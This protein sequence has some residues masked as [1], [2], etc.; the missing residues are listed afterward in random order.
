MIDDAYLARAAEDLKNRIG[1][2]S[3]NN[4]PFPILGV[5]LNGREVIVNTESQQGITE[6]TSVKLFDEKG[7]LITERS[8]H[9]FVTDKQRLAFRFEFE[10][11]SGAV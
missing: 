8:T 3:V 6:V 4:Q 7:G 2:L 9:I 11:R 1:S 5:T 10:V